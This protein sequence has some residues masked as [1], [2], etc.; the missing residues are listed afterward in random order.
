MSR[1]LTPAGKRVKALTWITGAQ[2]SLALVL[3]TGAAGVL[4]VVTIL[5][6]LI[7]ARRAAATDPMASL[8]A[9]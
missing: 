3:L 1:S 2:I 9:D 4:I 6:A 8:P 7:P 5:A